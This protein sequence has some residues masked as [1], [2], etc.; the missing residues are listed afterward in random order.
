MELKVALAS[1]FVMELV[2]TNFSLFVLLLR[3]IVDRLRFGFLV[4][5]RLVSILVVRE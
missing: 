5:F 2:V 3:I 4:Q 1:I